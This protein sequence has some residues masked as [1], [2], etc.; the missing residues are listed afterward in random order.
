MKYYN[1]PTPIAK[2]FI[3]R[4]ENY[5][6]HTWD[7]I[8]NVLDMVLKDMDIQTIKRANQ[9]RRDILYKANQKATS[10][11]PVAVKAAPIKKRK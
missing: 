2:R 8:Q 3:S 5:I 11:R 10:K 9:W 7:E 4:T 1:S 6:D